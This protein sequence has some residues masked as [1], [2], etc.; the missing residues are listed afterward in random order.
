MGAMAEIKDIV[1]TFEYKTH[2]NKN[3]V[4]TCGATRAYFDPIRFITNK[5]TGLMGHSIA[6]VYHRL[7]ANVT[8]ICAN[9]NF[10]KIPGIKYVDVETVDEMYQASI[11]AFSNTDYFFMSAAVS[12]YVPVDYQNQKIKKNDELI[13]IEL[14][15]SVDIL[16]ELGKLKTKQ[17]LIGFAAEDQ[18]HLENGHGK[19]IR[20]NLDY[21]I[22]ND[23]IAFDN[24]QNEVNII[25]KTNCYHIKEM[26]K[27]FIASEIAKYIK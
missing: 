26:N 7:G 18:N 15:K 27:S 22:V 5:S 25:D 14:K 20:K 9:T 23:L 19:L 13:T 16:F 10:M 12:D 4:V 24:K 17:V 8:C 6:Q 3:V 2:M 11:E 21:I 1:A